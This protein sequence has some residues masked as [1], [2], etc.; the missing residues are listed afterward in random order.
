MNKILNVLRLKEIKMFK[1]FC[2]IISKGI[3][4]KIF[5]KNIV[6]LIINI[7]RFCQK[8][9]KTSISKFYGIKINLLII[10]KIK[11]YL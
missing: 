2:K 3:D 5:K 7:C 6:S 8:S 9:K 10:Y 1:S 11:K 4:K